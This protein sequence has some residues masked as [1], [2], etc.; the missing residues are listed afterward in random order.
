MRFSLTRR[1]LFTP[2]LVVFALIGALATSM[3]T[4]RAATPSLD[5]SDI[6]PGDSPANF[7]NALGANA[8]PNPLVSSPNGHCAKFSVNGG[9]RTDIG[10]AHSGD[11]VTLY[12]IGGWKPNSP[13]QVWQSDAF[14]IRNP[15]HKWP[16]TNQIIGPDTDIHR[17]CRAILKGNQA[18]PLRTFATPQTDNG[19]QLAFTPVQF[20]APAVTE[21]SIVNI[22]ISIP[23]PPCTAL[24]GASDEVQATD[25]LLLVQPFVQNCVQKTGG[26]TCISI[27]PQVVYP[28]TQFTVTAENLPANAT[29]LNVVIGSAQGITCTTLGTLSNN[30][31]TVT[32]PPLSNLPLTSQSNGTYPF[33]VGVS[34]TQDCS[35]LVGQMQNLYV[36]PPSYTI[37]SQVTSG[38]TASITGVGWLG[39]A[40]GGSGPQPLQVVGYVGSANNFDCSKAATLPATTTASDGSFTLTYKAPDVNNTTNDKVIIAA[41]PQGAT[42]SN[43]CQAATDPSC[44]SASPSQNCPLIAATGPLQVV[45]QPAPNIPWLL[46]I[47][48]LLFLLPL[49]PLF[50]WLGRREEDELIVTEEDVTVE[51][52]VMDAT[53]S[54]RVADTTYA[55]TIR[56]TRERVRLRDGK[57]LDK[58]VEEYDVYRDAQGKEV[59][60]LRP[61]V[62]TPAPAP[63]ARPATGGATNV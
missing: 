21:A 52:E 20:L 28:G 63:S 39:G 12:G 23:N 62:T 7:Q 6:C 42:V 14:P 2:C 26:K 9:P 17:E 55:R 47:L 32:A 57:V 38:D 44:Q 5:Y 45:P 50:F 29:S 35:G 51:R 22:R 10:M 1:A 54:Q 15:N 4:A 30:S 53:N 61:P 60:R 48:P 40:A 31:A 24:P 25:A 41:F 36:S 11:L 27:D 33:K 46:I 13:V 58:E 43:G 19:D 8:N 49:L 56:L 34:T 59:R 16:L 37:P 18:N 3:T